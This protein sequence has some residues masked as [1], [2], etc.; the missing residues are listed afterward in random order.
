MAGSRTAFREAI[1]KITRRVMG[2]ALVLYLVDLNS[3]HVRDYVSALVHSWQDSET[4]H[5]MSAISGALDAEHI[6]MHRY[7]SPDELPDFIR[8]W[9]PATKGRDPSVDQW[10]VAYQL[11]PLAVGY[12]LRSCGPDATCSTKDDIERRSA[13]AV[14]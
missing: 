7:P 10:G 12:I 1:A 4:L 9:M 13:N 2:V 8:Q 3:T 6:S 14:D 5:E 11:E